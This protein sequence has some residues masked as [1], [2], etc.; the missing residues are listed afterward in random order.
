VEESSK[1]LSPF[2][3]LA[4]RTIGLSREH[5]A[6]NGKLKKQN[7]GLEK[8]YDSLL[9]GTK[10]QRLVRYA[11]GGAIPV[12]GFQIEPENGKDVFT[13]LDVNIQDI[14]QTA[15]LK[16]METTESIY[17][18][19]IVMETATGKIKAIANLGRRRRTIQRHRRSTSSN[20][21]LPRPNRVCPCHHRPAAERR[22]VRCNRP[23][24][25]L[26][27]PHAPLLVHGECS[28]MPAVAA[29]SSPNFFY[30]KCSHV[31]SKRNLLPC[32][33]LHRIS[34][35]VD[36]RRSPASPGTAFLALDVELPTRQSIG[37][38]RSATGTDLSGFRLMSCWTS[39]KILQIRSPLNSMGESESLVIR[40]LYFLLIEF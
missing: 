39:I 38:C 23:A 26:R 19:C 33:I 3:L 17:G 22:A 4:N 36:Q 14:A 27:W 30:L 24:T 9:T 37:H 35:R 34:R 1:R 15:L 18:T 28:P 2:G 29:L 21:T 32:P 40:N 13:T 10:G 20:V 6:S 7:V 11:S 8:S 25:M 12:E 5:V 31:Q 16:Q